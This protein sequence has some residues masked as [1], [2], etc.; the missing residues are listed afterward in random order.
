MYVPKINTPAG[1]QPLT[2]VPNN[3][4]LEAYLNSDASPEEKELARYLSGLDDVEYAGAVL[5]CALDGGALVVVYPRL[6]QKAPEGAR[7]VCSVPDGFLYLVP[8]TA[9]SKS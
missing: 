3:L 6:N 5:R 4:L 2:V 9:P 7:E 1:R 8:A